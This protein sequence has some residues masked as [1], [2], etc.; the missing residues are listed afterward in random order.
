MIRSERGVSLL[1]VMVALA[2][3]SIAGT[4][5]MVYLAQSYRALHSA[6]RREAVLNSAAVFLD[7]VS[8]WPREDLD[9]RLGSRRNGAWRLDIQRTAPYFYQ[10]WLFDSTGTDL[11]LSTALYRP[12]NHHD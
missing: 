5:F 7:A 9:R 6:E 1:E 3:L 10:V 4:S 2:I 11:L 12:D 8:L